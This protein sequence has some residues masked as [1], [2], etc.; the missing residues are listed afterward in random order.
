MSDKK[1]IQLDDNLVKGSVWMSIGSI[2]SRLI[3]ALYIIPWIIWMG[4]GDI[5]AGAN[6]LYQLAYTPYSF[7]IS[8]A[9]AGGPSAI[10]K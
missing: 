9:T 8:L 10:S 4:G 5:G 3:G 6:A 2:I 7:F 1:N